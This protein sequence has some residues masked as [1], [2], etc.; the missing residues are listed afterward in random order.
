[1]KTLETA[2][3]FQAPVASEKAHIQT[4]HGKELV[5]HYRWMQSKGSAEVQ[6]FLAEEAQ[7]AARVLEPLKPLQ[8]QL[9]S[10]FRSRMAPTK[11]SPRTVRNTFAYFSRFDEGCQY[12][13]FLRKS[14]LPGTHREEV[15]LDLN[16]FAAGKPF[17][18]IKHTTVSPCHRYFA[19]S[20]DL[21]GAEK[22]EVFVK[23]L[24]SGKII[25]SHIKNASSGSFVWSPDGRSLIYPWLEGDLRPAGIKR[26]LVGSAAADNVLF[27][28]W[29]PGYF[30]AAR[31]SG[32]NR[33]LVISTRTKNASENHFFDFQKPEKGLVCVEPRAA[34]HEYEI[35][36]HHEKIFITTNDQ[37]KCFRLMQA[38]AEFPRQK[39]WCEVLGHRPEVTLS[40]FLVLERALIVSEREDGLQ[41]LRVIDYK[42]RQSQRIALPD[43]VYAIMN[44]PNPDFTT[45]T[46]RFDYTSFT[47]P[48]SRLAFDLTSGDFTS[49][50]LTWEFSEF[51]PNFERSRYVTERRWIKARDG[52]SV[53]VTLLRLA[54]TQAKTVPAPCY[55]YGYGAYGM[56]MPV[57]FQTQR[58][59][60][61]DRGFVFAIAHVRGGGDMGRTWYEDGKFLKKKNTFH[62]FIDCA[63]SLIATQV[64]TSDQLVASGGSA[65]GLL[66]GAVANMRPDLFKLVVA[67]VPFVDMMNTM[68]DATQPLTVPEYNEW[69][70][71][72][73][74]TFFNYMLSYS[75]CDNVAAQN[76]PHIFAYG[77]VNDTRVYYWEPLKWV[78]KIRKHKTNESLTLAVLRDDQ[79]H[80]GASGRFDSLAEKAQEFAFVLDCVGAAR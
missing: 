57:T 33:Y 13:V 58:L 9:E 51:V 67:A 17:C 70:N 56:S 26:H 40:G 31:M 36:F 22:C 73:D 11:E 49:G 3:R 64:T 32:D 1:M 78:Q 53:P 80:G 71:P 46:L 74:E 23:D 19:W 2:A 18:A 65:G 60:L 12:P 8:T 21:S 7:Y 34:E 27:R 4:M 41:H 59:S 52:A 62:D 42:T 63:E 25:D 16:T 77:G 29:D 24:D 30:C 6:A 76:Y 79:G 72:N 50:A 14:V 66:M 75:P 61:V 47:T 5:D 55:L 15:L 48:P 68:L 38:D 69:G 20:V 28:E 43:S 54:D 44:A 35:E 37:A 39:H 10:E 45:Q